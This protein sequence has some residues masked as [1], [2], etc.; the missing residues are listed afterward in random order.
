MTPSAEKMQNPNYP[1]TV[2]ALYKTIKWQFP[3]ELAIIIYK[4]V[5]GMITI[6][7]IKTY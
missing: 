4:L 6:G 3:P 1:E 2:I 5:T 7:I